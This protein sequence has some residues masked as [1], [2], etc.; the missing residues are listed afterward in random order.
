LSNS[1]R[2]NGVSNAERIFTDGVELQT[3]YAFWMDPW[4]LKFS[5]S[6][7]LPGHVTL[8]I[9][10]NYLLHLHTFP[11]QT[12]PNS[13]QVGEG[14]EGTPYQRARA[15]LTYDQGPFSVTWTVRYVGKSADFV[16]DPGLQVYAEDAIAPA[17]FAPV[18]YNDLI[19]HYRVPTRWNGKA[20][21]FIG[22]DDLF[23]VL[24]PPNAITGNIAGPDGSALYDLGLYVFAG[25]RV[26]Y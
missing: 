22:A 15:D 23:N 8:N 17:Y 18:F 14:R 26:R 11:F 13:Y 12:Q 19:V 25:A 4:H 3:S 10:Y 2:W 9:D 7:D 24:P 1:I 5:R 6:A 20:D 21:L 16:K